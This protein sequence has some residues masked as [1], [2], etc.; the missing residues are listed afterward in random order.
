MTV[1]TTGEREQV[2]ELAAD[3][4]RRELLRRAARLD[5]A[6]PDALAHCWRALCEAGLE[7]ALIGEEHG[8]A[9]MSPFDLLAVLEEL[10]F[11]DGGVAMTILLSNV[12]LALME[13]DGA[14]LPE[15]GARWTLATADTGHGIAQYA[16][17]RL[18]GRLECV[19]GAAQADGIVLVKGGSSCAVWTLGTNDPGVTVTPD[20]RQLGL[21]AAPAAAVDLDGAQPDERQAPAGSDDITATIAL[22][23]AGTAAIARGIARRAYELALAYAHERRQGGV[24]IIEHEAVADMLSAMAVTLSPG[25]TG[26][27]AAAGHEGALDHAGALA[28]KIAATD[29]AVLVTTD[30]VQVFGGTGY[31]I[32]TGVEKLM[33]DAKYCHLF[34]TPNW[35]AHRELL[36]IASDR[37]GAPPA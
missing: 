15:P 1:S 20:K 8:G 4:A 26:N 6:D 24:P 11:G 25:P 2:R 30:A 28:A 14:S 34:P 22:L 23:Y 5:S 31:M 7:R 33:R 35:V 18:S 32:E 19:L 21:R 36:R 17:G 12:A 9:S 10:A 13:G 27:R 16:R 37:P 3:L 29:A